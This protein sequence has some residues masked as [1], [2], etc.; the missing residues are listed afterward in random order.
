MAMSG[1]SRNGWNRPMPFDIA[2]AHIDHARKPEAGRDRRGGDA[3]LAGA[4]FCDDARLAHAFGEKDL[5]DAIVDLMRAGVVQLLALEI[6]FRPT[7]MARQPL[8]EIE[9]ARAADIMFEKPIKLGGE[10]GIVLGR[11]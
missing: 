1:S 2:L 3:V 4:G 6:D 8:R 10:F 7:E 9:R 5:A 11:D